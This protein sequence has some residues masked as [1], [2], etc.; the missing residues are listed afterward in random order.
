MSEFHAPNDIPWDTGERPFTFLAG[1]IEQGAARDW[2]AEVAGRLPGTT[3]NPRREHW[4]PSWPQDISFEPFRQQVEWELK[5]LERCDRIVMHFEPE[6]KSPITLLEL[7]LFADS[8]KLL[9][10]CPEGYWRRGNVQITCDHYS[11][12]FYSSLDALLDDI[13]SP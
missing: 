12:P 13:S 4:D 3:L 6:T 10:S 11:V 1:S 7:G 8:G 9:V 5:A 2:Q